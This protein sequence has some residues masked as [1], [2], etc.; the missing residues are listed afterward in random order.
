MFITTQ[1]KRNQKPSKKRKEIGQLIEL[2]IYYL[3]ENKDGL[4]N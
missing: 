2:L 4:H 3:K 1:P